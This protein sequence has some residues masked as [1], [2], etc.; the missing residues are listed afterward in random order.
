MYYYYN[1]DPHFNLV[2]ILTLSSSR[3]VSPPPTTMSSPLKKVRDAVLKINLVLSV[4]TRN[5]PIRNLSTF[6]KVKTVCQKEN[7]T[8]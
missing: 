2:R 1:L 7:W 8:T 4:Y 6:R 3:A 5:A